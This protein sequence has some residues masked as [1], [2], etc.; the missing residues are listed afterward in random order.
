[1]GN[2]FLMHPIAFLEILKKNLNSRFKYNKRETFGFLLGYKK[3]LKI[4]CIS[5]FYIPHELINNESDIFYDQG[6]IERTADMYTKVNIKELIIGRYSEGK[7]L[8][9]LDINISKF[10]FCY[11]E[12]PVHL[13]I[14]KAVKNKGFF[15]NAFSLERGNTFKKPILKNIPVSVGIFESEE[16]GIFQLTKYARSIKDILI[17]KSIKTCFKTIDFF[18]SHIK[19]LNNLR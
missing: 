10:F 11:S 8:I 16:V 2:K 4:S 1:M 17:K 19:L 3:N 14:W 7:E 15:L 6:F 9:E 13:L 18:I 12:Y 5:A